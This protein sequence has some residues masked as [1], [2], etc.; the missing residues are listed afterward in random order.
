VEITPSPVCSRLQGGAAPD[1]LLLRFEGIRAGDLDEAQCKGSLRETYPGRSAHGDADRPAPWVTLTRPCSPGS[2]IPT[3]TDRSTPGRE[4]GRPDRLRPP[5]PHLHHR[6]SAPARLGS[7]QGGRARRPSLSTLARL[8]DANAEKL[9]LCPSESEFAGRREVE[10]GETRV[11]PEGRGVVRHAADQSPPKRPAASAHIRPR[12]PTATSALRPAS[13]PEAVVQA[14]LQLEVREHAIEA[15]QPVVPAR[16]PTA[17]DRRRCGIRRLR[18]SRPVGAPF[19][20]DV[21]HVAAGS[22]RRIAGQS[23]RLTSFSVA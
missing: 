10:C 3:K 21:D 13:I 4:P 6:R 14:R 23:A 9:E 15:R 11:V 17:L 16:P 12:Q 8:A 18:S 5:P 2:A 22:A 20:L 1:N 7:F 19:A